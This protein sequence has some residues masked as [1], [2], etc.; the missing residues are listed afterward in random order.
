MHPY[1]YYKNIKMP[2]SFHHCPEKPINRGIDG[3]KDSF[4]SLHPSFHLQRPMN[5]AFQHTGGRMEGV[6]GN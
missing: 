2:S 4:H 3:W 1:I 5:R 6:L